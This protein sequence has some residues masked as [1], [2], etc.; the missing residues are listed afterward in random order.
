MYG[1]AFV[2]LV[3]PF[4]VLYATV[5]GGAAQSARAECAP[6]SEVNDALKRAERSA[7]EWLGE[8]EAREL[9]NSLKRHG[10]RHTDGTVCFSQS[11]FEHF[12]ALASQLYLEMKTTERQFRPTFS[13]AEKDESVAS[14]S[15][16]VCLAC[17]ESYVSFCDKSFRAACCP[18]FCRN[19]FSAMALAALSGVEGS[20]LESCCEHGSKL[21]PKATARSRRST[22]TKAK[23]TTKPRF[24][25][26]GTTG[27]MGKQTVTPSAERSPEPSTAGALGTSL[28][29][30]SR[31][32]GQTSDIL[33]SVSPSPL[34][35]SAGTPP[36]NTPLVIAVPDVLDE[37]EEPLGS[38]DIEEQL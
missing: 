18:T 10:N 30:D 19:M 8:D 32:V 5:G 28:G 20:G 11:D 4:L 3:L 21:C 16:C 31:P 2:Q 29:G 34:P 25:F 38:L 26:R 23:A 9:M 36:E 13:G 24:N 6:S 14:S 35:R 37:E 15:Q 27:E 12:G 7:S 33:A 17:A 1:N 22:K